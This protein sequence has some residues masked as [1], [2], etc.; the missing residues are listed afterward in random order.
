VAAAPTPSPAPTPAA[1]PLP[2][3]VF[4]R[5]PYTPQA[6]NGNWDATHQQYCEAAATLMVGRYFRGERQQVMAPAEAERAMGQIVAY[7]R[8]TFPGVIDLKLE[9]MALVGTYFYDLKPSIRPATLEAVRQSLA[10]GLP[11]IIPVMTHGA[12]GAQK[13]APG[14]GARDVYHVILLVG[15]DQSKVY[16]NDAGFVSG[17]NWGYTWD[18]L[19]AAMEAQT[20]RMGQGRVMLTF[21]RS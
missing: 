5:V 4:I 2:P 8:D 15:Y 7:E 20:A 3:S 13:I 6:P 9:Q 16:A 11:V 12:P 10:A 19:Q 21:S 17:Q 1:T 18:V 14:F